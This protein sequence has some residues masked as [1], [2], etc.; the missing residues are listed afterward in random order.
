MTQKI[1]QALADYE[2]SEDRGEY[3]RELG[4]LAAEAYLAGWSRRAAPSPP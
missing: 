4:N 1:R 3:D 2:R